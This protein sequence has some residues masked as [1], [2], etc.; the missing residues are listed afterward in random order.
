MGL[1]QRFTANLSF[2][3]RWRA[4]MESKSNNNSSS[5]ITGSSEQSNRYEKNFLSI[6]LESIFIMM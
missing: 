3:V 5:K 6:F 4:R 2:I 1:K